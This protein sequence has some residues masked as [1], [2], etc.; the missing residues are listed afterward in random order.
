M[1]RTCTNN[2]RVH[3]YN[4]AHV[5]EAEGWGVTITSVWNR[6]WLYV[7]NQ[8][9]TLPLDELIVGFNIRNGRTIRGS[10]GLPEN[11]IRAAGVMEEGGES[12][13]QQRVRAWVDISPEG[14]EYLRANDFLLRIVCSA[15][16]LRP[17]SSSHPAQTGRKTCRVL[18]VGPLDRFLRRTGN[19]ATSHISNPPTANSQRPTV[20]QIVPLLSQP[21]PLIPGWGHYSRKTKH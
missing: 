11:S 5:L 4:I 6:Y 8:Y 9:Q 12:G 14:E 16:R 21:V 3:R 18:G 17:A 19:H 13:Q 1:A 20:P 10:E 15:V 2:L 7:P